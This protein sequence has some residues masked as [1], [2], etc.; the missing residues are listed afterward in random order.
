MTSFVRLYLVFGFSL[1]WPSAFCIFRKSAHPPNPRPLLQRPPAEQIFASNLYSWPSKIFS[2]AKNLDF[3]FSMSS[4]FYIRYCFT[5]SWY[6]GK[7]AAFHIIWVW[8]SCFQNRLENQMTTVCGEDCRKSKPT[9]RCS[10]HMW[11]RTCGSAHVTVHMWQY[12]PGGFWKS[13]T[14]KRAQVTPSNLVEYGLIWLPWLDS[15]YG[16]LSH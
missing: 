6:H 8:S 16:L 4:F 7:R 13:K 2:F 3:L 1:L 11:Q 15:F 10:V 14:I 9:L 12:C 5:E